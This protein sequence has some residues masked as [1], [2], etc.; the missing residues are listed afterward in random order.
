MFNI[1]TSPQVHTQVM[2][3]SARNGCWFALAT[4]PPQ[5]SQALTAIVSEQGHTLSI[6]FPSDIQTLK[7]HPLR[8]FSLMFIK[9]SSRYILC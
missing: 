4:G 8:S 6:M 9:Y 7:V 3:L 5:G 1:M 2:K